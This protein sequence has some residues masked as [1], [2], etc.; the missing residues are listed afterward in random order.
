[1]IWVL[2]GYGICRSF[3]LLWFYYFYFR[4]WLKIMDLGYIGVVNKIR[5]SKVYFRNFW[6][7]SKWYRLLKG[8]DIYIFFLIKDFLLIKCIKL[9]LIV[10]LI[11]V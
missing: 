2:K 1:M 5:F 9:K 8:N 4:G 6:I 10:W 7:L 11:N 3:I